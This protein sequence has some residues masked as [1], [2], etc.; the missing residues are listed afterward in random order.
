MR[1]GDPDGVGTAQ[2][3]ASHGAHVIGDLTLAYLDLIRYFARLNDPR[4]PNNQEDLDNI[5]SV[6]A[7]AIACPSKTECIG[8]PPFAAAPQALTH[9]AEPSLAT[10]QADRRSKPPISASD[11]PLNGC[12]RE[13]LASSHK[14]WWG[15]VCG[16]YP[17]LC[18]G[19]VLEPN[20]A[21]QSQVHT[22][23]ALLGGARTELL[24]PADESTGL[25]V[26]LAPD[27]DI[28]PGRVGH[29]IEVR[30]DWIVGFGEGAVEGKA[31]LLF[32]GPGAVGFAAVEH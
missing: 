3:D 14:Q 26:V 22:Y 10:A 30:E 28:A 15:I 24:P 1:S 23:R 7:L 19:G 18:S 2:R 8:L 31:H 25:G 9:C 17:R 27:G 13:G 32:V 11:T 29:G 16:M 20:G 5:A 12:R 6:V 4:S 21:C